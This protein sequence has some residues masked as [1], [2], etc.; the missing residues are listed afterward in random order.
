MTQPQLTQEQLAKL[1]EI[2]KLAQNTEEKLR[3]LD[4]MTATIEQ[5]WKR[6]REAKQ[7]LQKH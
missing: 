5:K 2:G 7:S 3:N 4:D 1:E 6:R